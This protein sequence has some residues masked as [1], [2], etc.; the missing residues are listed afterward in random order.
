MNN[1]G[2]DTS[3]LLGSPLVRRLKTDFP[4]LRF[5]SGKKF[6]FR[7]PRTIV[8]GPAEE[9]SDLLI[10]H[11][12]GHATL[13]HDNFKTDIDRLRM[14]S[15]AWDKTRELAKSYGV[16]FDEDAVQEELN[17]YR[18]WLHKKSRCPKCG[19]TRFQEADGVYHC[20]LCENLA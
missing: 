14:E 5:I 18:D 3:S 1:I 15:E 8:L 20:P 16:V 4:D 12:V 9:S 10:L 2:S 6:A 19:L 11:E 13:H 17:T 7:P